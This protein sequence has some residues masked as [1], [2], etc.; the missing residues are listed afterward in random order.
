[1]VWDSSRL[2]NCCQDSFWIFIKSSL[3]RFGYFLPQLRRLADDIYGV[4]DETIKKGKLCANGLPNGVYY[5]P[6]VKTEQ[7]AGL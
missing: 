3:G 1:M 4:F 7:G 2:R 5:K 6:G